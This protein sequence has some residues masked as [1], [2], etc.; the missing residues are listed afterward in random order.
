LGHTAHN[1]VSQVLLNVSVVQQ[2]MPVQWLA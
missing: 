1:P 2:D